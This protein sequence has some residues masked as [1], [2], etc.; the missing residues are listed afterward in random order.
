MDFEGQ[1]LFEHLALALLFMCGAI[2]FSIG[3]WQQ[4]FPLMAKI[5]G[6]GEPCHL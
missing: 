3:Y 4:D 5:Y 1:K 2:A 6:S